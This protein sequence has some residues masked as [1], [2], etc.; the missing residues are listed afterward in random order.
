MADNSR[1]AKTIYAINESISHIKQKASSTTVS[2]NP[3]TSNRISLNYQSRKKFPIKLRHSIEIA[4]GN[5]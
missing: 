4:H 1:R 5:P 3:S 2:K